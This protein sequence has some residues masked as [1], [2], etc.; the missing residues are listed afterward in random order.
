MRGRVEVDPF[1][2]IF[3]QIRLNPSHLPAIAL[4]SE[5][6]KFWALYQVPVLF[7]QQQQAVAAIWLKLLNFHSINSKIIVL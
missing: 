5:L 7:T 2:R 4:L 1:S 3:V 6:A